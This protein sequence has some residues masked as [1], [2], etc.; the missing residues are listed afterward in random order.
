MSNTLTRTLQ[1]TR[2][3]LPTTQAIPILALHALLQTT[4]QQPSV[5]AAVD[6]VDMPKTLRDPL[7]QV[8]AQEGTT[9]AHR[10]LVACHMAPPITHLTV[11]KS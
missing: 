5:I 4:L 8:M 10:L 11:F 6:Q 7:H 3:D 9:T 2:L 1:Q